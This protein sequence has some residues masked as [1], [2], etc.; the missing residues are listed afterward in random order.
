MSPGGDRDS[1][2][3]G[4]DDAA[5]EP[6]PGDRSALDHLFSVTYEELKRLAASVRR[7]DPSATLTPTALVNEA[8]LKLAHTPEVALTTPLPF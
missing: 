7:N 1:S 3:S 2:R 4:R 8:W 6:E 5:E